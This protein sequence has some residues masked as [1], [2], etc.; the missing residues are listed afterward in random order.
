MGDCDIR[1]RVEN[2]LKSK[3]PITVIH[4]ATTTIGVLD[5]VGQYG[6]WVKP[7]GLLYI[8]YDHVETVEEADAGEV[9]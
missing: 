9:E 2:L 4:N 7:N 1:C 6:F 5:G 8:P 3:L